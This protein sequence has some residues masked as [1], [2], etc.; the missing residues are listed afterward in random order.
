M[1]DSKQ[2]N[3]R[4]DGETLNNENLTYLRIQ[5]RL[6]LLTQAPR[7]ALGTRALERVSVRDQHAGSSVLTWIHLTQIC[8]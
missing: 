7:E 6:T 1:T 5:K 3:V 8:D 2:P 4:T